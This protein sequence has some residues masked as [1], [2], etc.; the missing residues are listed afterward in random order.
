[1]PINYKD[2]HPK[3]TLIRR[4]ILR[5]AHNCCEHCGAEN[6]Y[7]YETAT[8]SMQLSLFGELVTLGFKITKKIV[9]NIAHMDRDRTNNRFWN[10]K[11]LCQRCHLAHDKG[12][13][14]Y[15]FK[16]GKETQYQNGKLF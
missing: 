9:L 7:R 4:L 15:S 2:Y 13:R 12:Q 10:L 11:A 14:I 3:W 1:M 16:Y 5:R 8:Y 6:G